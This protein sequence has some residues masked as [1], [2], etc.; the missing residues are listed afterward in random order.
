MQQD[1]MIK[2][3]SLPLALLTDALT[4]RLRQ[5]GRAA[6]RI[7]AD[8]DLIELG[9]LDSQA[10]LDMILDVEQGSGQMF[11]ADGMDFERGVTLRR[12]AA[13]FAAPA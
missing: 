5:D 1:L 4:R 7:D 12:L 8:A 2:A 11:D 3:D 9:V 10:L 6:L 13:A